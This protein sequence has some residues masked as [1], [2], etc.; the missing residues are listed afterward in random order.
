MVKYVPNSSLAVMKIIHDSTQSVHWAQS[1][2]ARIVAGVIYFVCTT[3]HVSK[4]GWI[5]RESYHEMIFESSAPIGPFDVFNIIHSISSLSLGHIVSI[6]CLCGGL[7][8]YSLISA[9]SGGDWSDR[10]TLH[11][12]ESSGE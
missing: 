7:Y 10:L 12:K 3:T 1:H 6:T 8:P 2:C 11:S 5:Q 9:P 4:I